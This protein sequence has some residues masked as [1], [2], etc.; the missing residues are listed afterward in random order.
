MIAPMRAI[1]RKIA[2]MTCQALMPALAASWT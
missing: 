2:R 1:S